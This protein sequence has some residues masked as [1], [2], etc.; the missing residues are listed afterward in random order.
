M[1]LNRLMTGTRFYDSL[2]ASAVVCNQSLPLP[3]P[4]GGGGGGGS[5]MCLNPRF[6]VQIRCAGCTEAY[7]RWQNAEDNLIRIENDGF[8]DVEAKGIKFTGAL[9][10]CGAALYGLVVPGAGAVTVGGTCGF[11]A[12]AGV[13]AVQADFF[14]WRN[15]N[16]WR[17][18]R[19]R[20]ERESQRCVANGCE[21]NRLACKLEDVQNDA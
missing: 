15:Y 1:P 20:Y 3:D 17:G 8:P 4:G 13:D 7:R 16:N 18:T 19:D 11:A 10:V 6:K 9:A 21:I 12:Y 2:S 14:T 5:S